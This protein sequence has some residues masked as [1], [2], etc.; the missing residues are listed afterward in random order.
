MASRAEES[1]AHARRPFE[2]VYGVSLLTAILALIPYIIVTAA[3]TLF[4]QQVA[5]DIGAAPTGL[6]IINGLSTAGYAFGALLGGDLIN[7]Y[8]QRHLFLICEGLFILSCALAGAAGGVMTY[9]AG[10]VLQGFMTGLLLIIALPPVIQRFPARRMPTT[11]AA[12]NIGFF[13]AVTVGPLLG[14]IT[15]YGHAW[16]VFY[17]ALGA[18]G[19]LTW[20]L[21]FL[22]LPDADPPNPDMRF[23]FAAI[24]L[25]AP[26]TVL[27]F[28]AVGELTGP[29]FASPLFIAPLVLGLACF[30]ALLLVEYHR[31]EPL[32][33]VKQ[34]WHTLPLVGTLAAMIG[35]AA[36][37]TLL[38]LAQEYLLKVEHASMLQAGLTFWPQVVGVIITATLLG[39][40][41]R[42]RLL[43]FLVL[44]GMLVLLGAGA[45]LLTLQPGPGARTTVLAAAGLL[46]LGAGATV[47]PGLYLAAFSLPSRI[48]GRTFAL[49]E[50]VRSVADFILAPVTLGVA[51]V[52][53]G[54]L[55]PSAAGLRF[56]I[57][58]TLAVT[59]VLTLGGIALYL[60]G[61]VGL[62]R[63]DL[64]AW[65]E[66]NRPAIGSPPLAQK[67][68]ES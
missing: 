62:P 65:I 21:A 23:D 12:I 50:L 60:L 27:P 41:L 14:G 15:A 26:A 9:G 40:L 35:G 33:P 25:A 16:R 17:A 58:L 37:F 11:A 57:W 32:A 31:K 63:P 18:L 34:M 7:R 3:Y 59:A 43:P 48:V 64:V 51:R 49:V 55:Q 44:G 5:Q 53:S 1:A 10:R 19:C 2:G 61:G 22:T 30:V 6:E 39:L 8:Q 66:H 67:L 52:A 38:M 24:A 68:R 20:L 36:F 13:G 4:R 56:A 42:T 47:S 46:G 45:L 28:W 29:G 54:A